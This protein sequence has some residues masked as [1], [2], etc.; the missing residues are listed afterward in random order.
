[1]IEV[2]LEDV[3]IRLLKGEGE[4]ETPQFRGSSLRI[5]LLREPRSNESPSSASGTRP[6]TP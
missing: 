1:M 2:T 4:Q 6:S 3:V 5:I